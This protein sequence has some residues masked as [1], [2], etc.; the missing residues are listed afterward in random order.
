MKRKALDVQ[1]E[2]LKVIR[3]NSKISMSALERKIR[4]NPASLREHCQQLQ[5]LGL[6]K[7]KHTDKTTI[8]EAI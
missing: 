1:K 3:K 8:V 5:W 6:V 7:I 4:T 2:I